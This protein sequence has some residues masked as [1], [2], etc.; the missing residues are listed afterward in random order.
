[1]VWLLIHT[2]HFFSKSC[3]HLMLLHTRQ[4]TLYLDRG[5]ARSL[6]VGRFR[7]QRGKEIDEMKYFITLAVAA[8]VAAQVRGGAVPAYAADGA[9]GQ[10]GN[11]AGSPTITNEAPLS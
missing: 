11:G 9:D 7:N 4:A 2:R 5:F 8:F 3:T 10:N 6:W 1:M